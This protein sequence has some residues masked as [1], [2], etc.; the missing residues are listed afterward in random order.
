MTYAVGSLVKARGREWVVLP[1]SDGDLLV[2][3]PLG[4]TED[5][6]TGV[7]TPREPVQPARFGLPDP[8]RPG[9]H[10]S[11]RLLRNAVR[12]GFRSSAGPLRSFAGIA[13]APRPY[14]LVPRLM[15]LKLDRCACSS[16]TMSASAKR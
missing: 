15:A 9:D 14:E 7:Y 6:V 4:S 10:R 13:V 5:E 12:L 11:S 8:T 2:L 3:R 16:P 1:E